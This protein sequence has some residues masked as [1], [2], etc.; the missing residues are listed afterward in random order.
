MT[1]EWIKDL[2]SLKIFPSLKNG[3]FNLSFF[4]N[5]SFIK[6]VNSNS[7]NK[8]T[9]GLPI[10]VFDEL[11]PAQL[12]G[13]KSLILKAFKDSK[14]EKT[15]ILD[16]EYVK[17]VDDYIEKD[18]NDEN[19]KLI[20]F[21]IG[22]IPDEDIYAL[23]ASSYIEKVFNEGKSV[24]DLKKQLR[25]KYGQ[26]GI[27]ISNL[28]SAG[29]FK[30]W[31]KPLYENTSGQED[32]AKAYELAVHQSPFA[33]FVNSDM[34]IVDIETRVKEK[35]IENKSYGIKNINIH[36]I[37]SENIKKIFKATENLTKDLKNLEV[38]YEN[39]VMFVA[40]LK[41]KD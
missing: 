15:E 2:I 36:G 24:H 12:K 14:E 30:T 29:Y 32:F 33:I 21:F 22:K 41:I 40:K 35:V 27:N 23:K 3:K 7:N 28:F 31:V 18:K 5:L 6:I 25:Y 19:S 10:I 9:N 13:F 39:A 4:K 8:I 17:E 1:P 38:T 20:E 16:A 11:T 37:G 34:S 26:R